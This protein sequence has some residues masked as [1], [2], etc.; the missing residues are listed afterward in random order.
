MKTLK[1]KVNHLDK[2]HHDFENT[3]LN[4]DNTLTTIM[5]PTMNKGKYICLCPATVKSGV[6][7]GDLSLEED[8]LDN[9]SM[10]L[11]YCF[12]CAGYCRRYLQIALDVTLKTKKIVSSPINSRGENPCEFIFEII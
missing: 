4:S 1:E 3:T 8:D 9:R 2:L 10:P 12:C 7:V 5:L 6:K 11:S